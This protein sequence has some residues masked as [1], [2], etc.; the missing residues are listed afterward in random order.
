MPILAQNTASQGSS[1]GS[2]LILALPLLLIAYMIFSQRRRQKATQQ[3]QAELQV[4]EKVMTTTG[5]FGT[6][7]WMDD[8]RVHLEVAPGVVLEWDRRAI[9]RVPDA[10]AGSGAPVEPGA[11][12]A[13][14]GTTP[15]GSEQL[16]APQGR[17]QLGQP[18]LGQPQFDEPGG[19][20]LDGPVDPSAGEHDRLRD[21]R[22]D[23]TN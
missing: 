15:S 21:P 5:L 10:I 14:D 12:G 9:V 8:R 23:G 3:M 4:G 7:R 2:L 22:A 19:Q 6:L 17:S 16:D 18:Q 20:P 13:V 11:D 1:M